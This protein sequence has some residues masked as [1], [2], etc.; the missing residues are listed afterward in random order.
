MTT[1]DRESALHDTETGPYKW[2]GKSIPRREDARF[3]TGRATYIGDVTVPGILHAAVLR[4]P[5]AHALIVSI[6]TRAAEALPGVVAVLTGAQASQH[7]NPMTAFCAEPV[8][9]HAIAV[10]KVRFP[11]EAVAAVAA[12]DRY[13]AEDA[14]ALIEVT[15]EVLPPVVDPVDA[16]K[17]A[18]P[19]STTPSTA[20]WSSTAA[21][22]SVTSTATSPALPTL[23]TAPPAGTGWARSPWRPAGRSAPGTRSRRR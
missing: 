19:S 13:I 1:I 8:V 3:L 2:I 22:T 11:G 17:E 4:S 10:N 9:Q 12:T 16:T 20:T 14:C 15:Y 5:H 21:S 23:S 18:A 6:D 7:V